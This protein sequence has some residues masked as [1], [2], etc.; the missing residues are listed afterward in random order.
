[1]Q[2]VTEPEDRP[3]LPQLRCGRWLIAVDIPHLLFVTAIA[4]WCA[5]YW[6]DAW[7]AA[8]DIQNLSL[9]E[10]TAILAVVV[11][12]LILPSCI[13][14]RS[15]AHAA[16]P[17]LSPRPALVP[18]FRTRIIGAMLLLALYVAAS[19]TIG[20]DVA[21]FCYILATLLF[22][23]E[24]RIAVLLLASAGF[25]AVAI[26]CFDTILATPLPL[27]FFGAEQ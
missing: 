15:A 21:S 17:V 19:V 10:P 8:A 27:F 14:I 11:Y 3:R 2:P 4:G 20:F 9:I 23:G 25:C 6:L 16:G 7:M 22:L 13:R 12:L 24:R 1:M 18:A 5:W 26:Y